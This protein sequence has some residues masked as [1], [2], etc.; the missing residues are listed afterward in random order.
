VEDFIFTVY[1]GPTMA[2][3]VSSNYIRYEKSCGTN[4]Y[5]I[6]PYESL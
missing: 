5:T 3:Y 2:P 4:L 1:S 6:C